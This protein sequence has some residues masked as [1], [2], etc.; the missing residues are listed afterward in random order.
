MGRGVGYEINEFVPDKSIEDIS[1]TKIRKS[2]IE[3]TQSWTEMVPQKI[4]NFLNKNM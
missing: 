1:A 2:L 4:I 3:K